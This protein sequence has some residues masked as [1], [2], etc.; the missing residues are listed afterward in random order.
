MHKDAQEEAKR[1]K[2]KTAQFLPVQTTRALLDLCGHFVLSA[3]YWESG[4]P[5]SPR[6]RQEQCAEHYFGR[7]KAYNRGTRAS[8]TQSTACRS[9]MPMS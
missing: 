6:S 1:L 7:A 3:R 2:L 9:Y 8:R 4:L 5:W